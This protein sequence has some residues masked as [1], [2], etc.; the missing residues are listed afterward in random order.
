M[1]LSGCCFFTNNKTEHCSLLFQQ[2]WPQYWKLPAQYEIHYVNS[3][4]DLKSTENG[5][6]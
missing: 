6:H 3:L 2:L 5:I 1:I 4:P